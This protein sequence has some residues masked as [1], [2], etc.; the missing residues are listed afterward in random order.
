VALYILDATAV[1]ALEDCCTVESVPFQ[2]VLD[3]LTGLAEM[4]DF[5][6]PPIVVKQVRTFADGEFVST[7]LRS[8]AGHFG[9]VVDPWDYLETV[10]LECP[11]L[12]DP[13][14]TQES[15]QAVVLALALHR[16]DVGAEV[17]VVTDQWSDLPNR[18]SLG[19]ACGSL[20]IAAISVHELLTRLVPQP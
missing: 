12:I 19:S 9:D 3:A 7:W 18:Q 5:V 1:V 4:G 6:C 8:T 14:S 11:G 17:L 20:G 16:Q 2:A 13:D 15:P 10:L